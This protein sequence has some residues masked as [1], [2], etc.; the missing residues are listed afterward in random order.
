MGPLK[1]VLFDV[2]GTLIDSQHA[3]VAAMEAAAD[4]ADLPT[5]T[6]TDTLNVVGLSLVE[7]PAVVTTHRLEILRKSA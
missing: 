1:L 4:E 7:A 6:R 2:D 3:I 5:P